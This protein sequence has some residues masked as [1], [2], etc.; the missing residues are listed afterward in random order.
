MVT[1][2]LLVALTAPFFDGTPLP[3]VA[4][5]AFCAAMA[6]L[7]GFWVLSRPTRLA[8]APAE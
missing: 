1:G 7:V 2:S 5:I 6:A 4:T 3:M 8:P